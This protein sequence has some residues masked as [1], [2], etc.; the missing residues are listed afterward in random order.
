MFQSKVIDDIINVK[1]ES[2]EV[3]IQKKEKKINDLVAKLQFTPHKIMMLLYTIYGTV[4]SFVLWVLLI[5]TTMSE[6][7]LLFCIIGGFTIGVFLY[8]DDKKKFSN[9]IKQLFLELSEKPYEFRISYEKE[10]KLKI[11]IEENLYFNQSHVIKEK[12]KHLTA[13]LDFKENKESIV[14]FVVELVKKSE[15]MFR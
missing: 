3:K 6:T 12:S 5:N 8:N 10:Q 14:S 13:Y 9:A 4:L 2:E 15:S 7:C 11:V 1:E